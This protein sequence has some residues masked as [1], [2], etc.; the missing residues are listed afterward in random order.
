MAND[1]FILNEKLGEVTIVPV[2]TEVSLG[3]AALPASS[4]Q[5][6]IEKTITAIK[7]II[8]AI[9]RIAAIRWIA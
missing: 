3:A 4:L 1:V 9:L 2:V 7:T 6:A 5:A 8:P